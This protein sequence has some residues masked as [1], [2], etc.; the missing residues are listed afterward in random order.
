MGLFVMFGAGAAVALVCWARGVAM[1]T[2][3]PY[4]VRHAEIQCSLLLL[5]CVCMCGHVGVGA[6]TCMSVCVCV[7]VCE[8]TYA[9]MKGLGCLFQTLF[10][11]I[12]ESRSLA[13]PSGMLD[14]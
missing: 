12:S 1:R 7:C 11:G 5:G 14:M 3:T 4:Q 2:T 6:C 9:L 8:C 13:C 10:S